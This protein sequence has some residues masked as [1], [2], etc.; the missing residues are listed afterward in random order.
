MTLWDHLFF[1]VVFFAI[2]IYFWRTN[3]SWVAEVDSRGEPARI[4]GYRETI[5]IWLV[6]ALAL[7]VLWVTTG[8]E[9]SA[10]G[11]RLSNPPK[12]VLGVALSLSIVA[13]MWWQ[14]R[15]MMSKVFDGQVTRDSLRNHIGGT[16]ALVPGTQR[17]HRWFRAL[18]IN[19]GI[20]EELIYRGFL[21]WYL[22]PMVGLPIAVAL[23]IALFAFGHCYQGLK[24]L[25]GI[26]VAAGVMV[27]LYLIS[28]SIWLPML[29]H[30]TIDALQGELFGKKLQARPSEAGS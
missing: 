23:A 1:V 22:E 18:S 15:L 21:L 6:A 16:E 9:W 25:P 3:Q 13:L 20:T 19:A 5:A 10:L 28:G 11:M 26:A 14:L 29:V 8:R 7:G 24:Q 4:A 12:F 30:A 17:E 27:A 2:P